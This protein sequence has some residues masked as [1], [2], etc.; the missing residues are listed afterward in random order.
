VKCS[1]ALL[2]KAYIPELLADVNLKNQK[3]KTRRLPLPELQ[4]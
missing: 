1:G 3:P 2:L 4:S